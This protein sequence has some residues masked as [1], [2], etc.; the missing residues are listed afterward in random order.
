MLQE[1]A[2]AEQ[3]ACVILEDGTIRFYNRDTLQ[4][5]GIAVATI[6]ADRALKTLAV[7]EAIDTVRNTVRVAATQYQVQPAIVELWALQEVVSLAPGETR[8]FPVQLAGPLVEFSDVTREEHPNPDGSGAATTVT[9][10]TWNPTSP[11]RGYIRIA[12]PSGS[13]VWLVDTGGA[14]SLRLTGRVIVTTDN[15]YTA[16]ATDPGSAGT[17]GDQPLD[18]SAN[19]FRQTGPA[20]QALADLL[21]AVL[22]VPQ[23][24]VSGVEVV[25]DPRRQLTDRVSVIDPVSGLARDFMLVGIRTGYAR[26]SGLTQS[27]ALRERGSAT[28]GMTGTL[29]WDSGDVF[30]GM[31][32]WA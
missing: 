11:T 20:A 21:L 6:T 31:D 18:V 4:G 5:P 1:I 3:G 15:P 25:G 22:A 2:E 27:L 9:L 26:G 32:G 19:R 24:L 28:T 7:S 12:N 23:A 29:V 8:I 13:T 14:A 30:D 16:T 17:Y 10:R